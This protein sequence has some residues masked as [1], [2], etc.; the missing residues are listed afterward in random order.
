MET[1]YKAGFL[2]VFD[3]AQEALPPG[4]LVY[5]RIRAI[6]QA[7]RMG[8]DR[9][10]RIADQLAGRREAFVVVDE[11]VAPRVKRGL[12]QMLGDAPARRGVPLLFR[13]ENGMFVDDEEQ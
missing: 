6:G 4:P 2:P 7:A 12:E 8:A 3:A 10:Q 5:T 13:P 11:I 1:A 9:I